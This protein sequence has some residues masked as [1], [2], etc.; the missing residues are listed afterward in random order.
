MRLLAFLII[1]IIAA[2]AVLSSHS[3]KPFPLL[4]DEAHARTIVCNPQPTPDLIGRERHR[5]VTRT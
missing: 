1:L 4:I 3:H 2:C 5:G